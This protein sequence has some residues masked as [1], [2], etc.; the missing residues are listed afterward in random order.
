[1][2]NQQWNES[3]LEKK[4]TYVLEVN[5]NLFVIEN[6]PARV[7]VETGEKFFSPQTVERLQ[8]TIWEKQKPARVIE[9]PVF[10]FAM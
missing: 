1:M 5:G 10:E 4:V 3:L 7:N 6:V 9:T 2:T 8:K